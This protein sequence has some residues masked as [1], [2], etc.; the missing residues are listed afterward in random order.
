MIFALLRIDVLSVA[1]QR[2]RPGGDAGAS[3]RCEGGIA[4]ALGELIREALHAAVSSSA[5]A[6]Q[7][8]D[9]APFELVELYVI[10]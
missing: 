6:A 3:P 2:R 7:T 1:R 8:K 5:G 9:S 4:G 10:S